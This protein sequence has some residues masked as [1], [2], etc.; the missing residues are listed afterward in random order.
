MIVSCN[1]S[2]D[3]NSELFKLLQLQEMSNSF[4]ISNF[5]EKFNKSEVEFSSLFKDVSLLGIYSQPK[6]SLFLEISLKY[7]NTNGDFLV[8]NSLIILAEDVS[9]SI[10]RSIKLCLDTFS[11]DYVGLIMFKYKNIYY[12]DVVNSLFEDFYNYYTTKKSE[13]NKKNP[14]QIINNDIFD[15]LIPEYLKNQFSKKNVEPNKEVM[16]SKII[17]L[18]KQKA[19]L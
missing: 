4:D 16:K 8:D 17:K 7:I 11:L 5:V 14:N 9:E 2:K 18:Y 12:N 10:N 13:I 15:L 3:L 19:S 1:F 6:N